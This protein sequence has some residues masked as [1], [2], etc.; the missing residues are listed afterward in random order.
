MLHTEAAEYIER[1]FP[2]LRRKCVVWEDDKDICQHVLFDI[3]KRWPTLEITTDGQFNRTFMRFFHQAK[4]VE[5]TRRARS[6]T[7]GFAWSSH[8]G[9]VPYTSYHDAY[10]SKLNV[11]AH[12]LEGD[13]LQANAH[14]PW[15]T[16]HI[17][18]LEWIDMLSTPLLKK[19]F[20][21]HYIEGYTQSEV[22]AQIGSYR[23]QVNLIIAEGLTFLRAAHKA[24]QGEA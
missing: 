7:S 10:E 23:E 9:R 16:T 22:A 6:W 14:N 20:T 24:Q 19:I 12:G 15:A 18:A 17:R 13:A 8:G 21:M 4:W 3:L 11:K 2:R 5:R 1:L